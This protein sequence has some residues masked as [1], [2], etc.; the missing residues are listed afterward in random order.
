MRLSKK[1][2]E[3]AQGLFEGLS[4]RQAFIRAGYSHEGKSE[5]YLDIEACRVAKNPSV[6]E[7]LKELRQSAE[8]E[9]VY[10]VTRLIQEFSELKEM[11]M[12]VKPVVKRG[13]ETGEYS[14]DSAGANRALENIG[15]LLG[16]Y[17]EKIEQN[18]KAEGNF[19]LK[20]SMSKLS[21]EELRK[22]IEKL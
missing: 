22:L 8:E 11:C 17:T 15:K 5:H 18:I 7:R 1:Q 4:Q 14:F 2:E 21:D 9:S 10:T 6:K 19:T 16:Y 13:K 3:F 20:D 12:K